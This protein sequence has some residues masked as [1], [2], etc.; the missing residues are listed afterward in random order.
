MGIED[1]AHI[2]FSAEGYKFEEAPKKG[3]DPLKDDEVVASALSR[4]KKT[5]M[6]S[7]AAVSVS[8]DKAGAESQTEGSDS[9][10]FSR[11]LAHLW[12]LELGDFTLAKAEGLK[13]DKKHF[14]QGDLGR[15]INE[16][17]QTVL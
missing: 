1:M 3:E 6:K 15:T 14:R 2:L 4:R 12:P 10:V 13:E 7:Q 9:D 5:A 17:V 16:V 11:V 8:E